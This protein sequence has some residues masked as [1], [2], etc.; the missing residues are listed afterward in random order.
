[1]IFDKSKIRVSFYLSKLFTNK[2]LKLRIEIR[3][4]GSKLVRN[5]QCLG[6]HDISRSENYGSN[7]KRYSLYLQLSYWVWISMCTPWHSKN[8]CLWLG[9][10]FLLPFPTLE[11]GI[12]FLS[13]L[14]GNKLVLFRLISLDSIRLLLN[15]ILR[16]SIGVRNLRRTKET[17]VRLWFAASRL[18]HVQSINTGRTLD[19]TWISR[20]VLWLCWA[21]RGS[22]N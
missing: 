22:N 4:L 19:P 2:F 14:L 12:Y 15:K 8:L 13:T 10:I 7:I 18:K 16:V 9:Y 6:T 11:S 17:R 21:R 20:D 5:Y 1:M 3:N